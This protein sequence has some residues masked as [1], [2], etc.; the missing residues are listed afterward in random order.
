MASAAARSTASAKRPVSPIR[1]S[2]GNT[3]NVGS[4]PSARA[5]CAASAIAGAVL[6]PA[7]SSRMGAPSAPPLRSASAAMKRWASLVTTSGA[8][9]VTAATRSSVNSNRLRPSTSGANCLE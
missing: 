7:G 4:P 8:R 2:D 3:N 5:S 9:S 6:R 1:W